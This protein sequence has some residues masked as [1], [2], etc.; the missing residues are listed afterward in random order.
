MSCSASATKR[1]APRY[2]TSH[3][4]ATLPSLRVGDLAPVLP[5][6][7]WV[8]GERVVDFGRGHVR[9]LEFWAPWCGPCIDAMAHV[10]DV[11]DRFGDEV[12][13]IA[14]GILDSGSTPE[15]IRATVAEQADRL[16]VR[17]AVDEGNAG[18]ERYRIG[19]RDATV[20][21]A[22]IIDRAGRVA[23]IGHPDLVDAPLAAVIAGSWDIDAAARDHARRSEIARA[24]RVL[25]EEY[26]A[27]WDRGDDA[28]RLAAAEKYSEYPVAE[29]D[30]FAPPWFSWPAR[31][32]LLIK[33]GRVTDAERVAR[34][35][36]EVPGVG[37]EPMALCEI[38]RFLSPGAPETA[39]I[40]AERA[41]ARL[42]DVEREFD[43]RVAVD[44][45]LEPWRDACR[46]YY[47]WGFSQIAATMAAVGR[48]HDAVRYERIAIERWPRDESEAENRRTLQTLLALYEA[49]Q[50]KR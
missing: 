33:A 16:R 48:Y 36:T 17:V 45:S 30:G 1:P 9:V 4:K 23:W 14:I 26:V 2:F 34:E 3:E 49:E 18:T 5:L 20:P 41:A 22:F 27:A 39:L 28:G 24:T 13:V 44:P 47:A 19:A 12:I 8:Q 38:V 29:A 25:V 21:L 42:A 11:Q 46:S 10:S 37:D 35:A 40:L 7:N 6:D 50:A 32:E 15:R 31:V 43:C